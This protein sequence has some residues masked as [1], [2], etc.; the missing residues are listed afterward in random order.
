MYFAQA[1]VDVP[2][3]VLSACKEALHNLPLTPANIGVALKLVGLSAKWRKHRYLIAN[4]LGWSPP[5]FRNGTDYAEMKRLF[6]FVEVAW[7]RKRKEFTAPKIR[8]T[9]FSYPFL[10]WKLCGVIGRDECARD[11][12]LLKGKPQLAFQESMWSRCVKE[13]GW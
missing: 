6:H 10:F 3:E 13:L 12:E 1:V 4:C 11:V 5:R 7:R 2:P 8:K 9:F